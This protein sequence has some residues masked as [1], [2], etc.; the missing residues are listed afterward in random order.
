MFLKIVLFNILF[1]LSF[2]SFCSAEYMTLKSKSLVFDEHLNKIFAK[3]NIEL[4]YK[5]KKVLTDEL[6]ILIDEELVITSGDVSVKTDDESFVNPSSLIINLK[7][8]KLDFT[9][10]YVFTELPNSDGKI[11]VS[12]KQLTSTKQKYYGKYSTFTTCDYPEPHYYLYSRNFI[13][14]PDKNIQL[15]WAFLKNDLSFFPFNIIPFS[16]PIIEF[17]PLPLYYY[18][19]GKRKVIYN[20]PTIGKKSTQGWGYFVQN[21][22]DYRYKNNNSSSIY[23]DWYEATHNRKGEFGYGLNHHFGNKKNFGSFYIYNYNYSQ[24]SIE[25]QNLIYKLDHHYHLKNIKINSYYERAKIDERI[26]STGS[27]DSELKKFD[28]IQD[29]LNFPLK[30]NFSDLSQYSSKF[31]IQTLSL[32]KDF[33]HQKLNLNVKNNRYSQTGK[34]NST[35]TFVH[36]KKFRNQI[37]INQNIFFSSNKYTSAQQNN[38]ELLKYQTIVTKKL[39][40]NIDFQLNY[41]YL[42][43]LDEERVTSDTTSGANNYLYKLP[44]LQLKKKSTFF[45]NNKFLKINSDS[46]VSLGRYKEVLNTLETDSNSY[47]GKTINIEPNV[48]I[49]K[50]SLSNT[51][52]FKY[53]SS[54]PQTNTFSYQFSYEQ[55]I[56]KNKNLSLFEGDAQYFLNYNTRYSS[57]YFNFFR[58]SIGFYRT[59]GHKDNNSSFYYFNKTNTERH[60]LTKTITLFYTKKKTKRYPFTFNINWNNST[61]YNWLRNNAHYSNYITSIDLNLNNKYKFRTS[62]SKKLNI[63]YNYNNKPYGP[64]LITFNGNEPN[65][66]KFNYSLNLDLNEIVFKNTSAVNSS[67]INFEFPIGRNKDFQW[68]I[69]A[70]YIYKT[71]YI[72]KSYQLKNYQYQNISVTKHEHERILELGYTKLTD[73]LFF[74]YTFKS[75]PKDPFTMRRKKVNGKNSWEIE[76][77]LKQSSQERFQ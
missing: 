49:F 65:K 48:Y 29:P 58:Q 35:A 25:K 19:L 44:E 11:Y 76:G 23:I 46:F 51:S 68:Y 61:G 7:K 64:L 38:D 10:I 63:I 71:S 2:Y 56:F 3:G 39:P 47:P 31:D 62:S 41:N 53:I 40:K 26:N 4:K 24:N 72:G 50:Q 70:N 8:E 16:V 59:I 54:L 12:I 67:Q 14:N 66:F 73:E 9:D 69:K 34:K 75:F 28:Y 5:D 77:R 6:V 60:E 30:I 55:Y 33:I 52:Q 74:K 18:Q 45:Q 20:F 13:F 57:T 36:N 17:I 1:F 37:N 15:Y 21:Q 32:S 43:D 42:L 22:I 27:T